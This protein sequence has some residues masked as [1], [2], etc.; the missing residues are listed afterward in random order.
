MNSC[1]F[2]GNLGRDF[3]IAYTQDG[4]AVAKNSMAVRKFNGDTLWINIIAFGK[5][6]ETLA[7]YT[8]KGANLGIQTS[9][10]IS[11][12]EKEGRKQY[13]YSFVI[14]NFT[15]TG[16]QQQDNSGFQQDPKQQTPQG[17]FQQQTSGFQQPQNQGGFQQPQQPETFGKEM[18]QQFQ[19][20]DDIPF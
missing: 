19:P 18:N 1:N 8:A 2:V 13:Y 15:L 17:G 20:D 5:R 7:K 11:T 9:L 12:Y 14:E 6:A 3:E 16:K 10:D 4:K